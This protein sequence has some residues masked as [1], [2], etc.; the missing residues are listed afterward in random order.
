M[1]NRGYWTEGERPWGDG[2]ISN[3]L[4]QG[5]P[6]VSKP[7]VPPPVPSPGSSWGTFMGSQGNFDHQRAW[8]LGGGNRSLA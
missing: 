3:S 2:S 5:D 6:S 7:S 8:A 1:C 4:L